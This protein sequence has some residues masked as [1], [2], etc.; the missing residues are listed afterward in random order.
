MI[1]WGSSGKGF[2][3]F[4]LAKMPSLLSNEVKRSLKPV[5]ISSQPLKTAT[6]YHKFIYTLIYKKKKKKKHAKYSSKIVIF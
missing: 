4:T 3:G 6:I 1:L 2:E 5:L